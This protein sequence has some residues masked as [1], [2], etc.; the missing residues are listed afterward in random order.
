MEV[1]I[2]FEIIDE[3]G[4]LK[5]FFLKIVL[6]EVFVEMG[7]WKLFELEDF[8]VL[9]GL[10]LDLVWLRNVMLGLR[11]MLLGENDVCIIG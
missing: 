11:I 3:I 2:I 8:E 9:V 5:L 4:F 10:K 7:S 6:D 1:V